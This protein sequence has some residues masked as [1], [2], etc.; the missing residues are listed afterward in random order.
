MFYNLITCLLKNLF[1]KVLKS[2]RWF[3]SVVD[4]DDDMILG[5]YI[6]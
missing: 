5:H 3:P 1:P 6:T 4:P 2:L